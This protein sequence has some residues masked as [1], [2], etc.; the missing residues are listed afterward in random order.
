MKTITDSQWEEIKEILICIAD[1]L[2]HKLESPKMGQR[3]CDLLH[4]I[5]KGIPQCP[6]PNTK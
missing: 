1:G 3:V 4:E 5:R 6:N 2:T